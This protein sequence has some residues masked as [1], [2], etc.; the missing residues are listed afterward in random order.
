MRPTGFPCGDALFSS[1]TARD[2]SSTPWTVGGPRRCGC[3]A[4]VSCRTQSAGQRDAE[5]GEGSSA[6]SRPG[7]LVRRT[8]SPP[9]GVERQRREAPRVRR[10]GCGSPPC[11]PPPFPVGRPSG[12]HAAASRLRVAAGLEPRGR[13]WKLAVGP[14]RNSR[15]SARRHRRSGRTRAGPMDQPAAADRPAPMGR[16][17]MTGLGYDLPSGVGRYGG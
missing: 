17:V 13:S 1:A 4:A 3:Q 6:R 9:V 15:R 7:G 2:R 8:A 11:Y 14:R 5:L 16:H 10:H 12:E